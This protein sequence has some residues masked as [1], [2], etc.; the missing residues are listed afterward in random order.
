MDSEAPF[1]L[2]RHAI[3]QLPAAIFNLVA[4][5]LQRPYAAPRHDT[6]GPRALSEEA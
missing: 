6:I 1:G 5:H 4:F 3:L 2:C